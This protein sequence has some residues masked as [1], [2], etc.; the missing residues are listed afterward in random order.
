V[1]PNPIFSKKK[2]PLSIDTFKSVFTE[3][4]YFEAFNKP[5]D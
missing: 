2:T 4:G 1:K 3:G 5:K